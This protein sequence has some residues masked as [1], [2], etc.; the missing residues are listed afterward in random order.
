[1]LKVFCDSFEMKYNRFS[2]HFLDL[3]FNSMTLNITTEPPIDQKYWQFYRK[4]ISTY[5]YIYIQHVQNV[6]IQQKTL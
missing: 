1:M 3:L 2:E 4:L 6:A 5:I